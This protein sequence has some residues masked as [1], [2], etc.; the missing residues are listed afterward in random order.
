MKAG[1][2][3]GIYSIRNTINGKV[4]PGSSVD[5]EHRWVLHRIALKNG[6]HHSE[7]LQRAW[8][9][10]G[11]DNFE[12]LA[13]EECS[14]DQLLIREQVYLDAV[15]VR[16]PD[17][18]LGGIDH[19]LAYNTCPIAG[20]CLGFRHSE[21]SRR[22]MSEAHIGIQAGENHPMYG[23]CHSEE[24]K[25]KISESRKGI[26]IGEENSMYGRR[27]EKSVWFG[28]HHSLKTRQ[29]ISEQ[30]MGKNNH[31]FGKMGEDAA[32]VKL[33]WGKVNEIREKH[34]TGNYTQSQLSDEY[35]IS[36]THMSRILNNKVWTVSEEGGE[37]DHE[38]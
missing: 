10:Y 12:F 23:K 6:K 14:K 1:Y 26:C 22:K 4:Y 5:I 20:N 34:Q 36:K 30:S 15:R 7:H 3:T 38:R 29:L 17:G 35:E 27:G 37:T 13:L 8:S 31:C 24:T 25:Q 21:E 32:N 9:K 18:T 2:N 33:T 19:N 11:E 16:N 28:K